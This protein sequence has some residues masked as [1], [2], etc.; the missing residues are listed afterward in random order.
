MA[1]KTKSSARNL[2]ARHLSP[3]LLVASCI[4]SAPTP[5][6]P[7]VSTE[8]AALATYERERERVEKRGRE[9]GKKR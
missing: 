6:S 9:G 5:S 1:M 3:Q 7:V 4:T 2:D 8:K